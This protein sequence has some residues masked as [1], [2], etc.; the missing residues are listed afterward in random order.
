[1]PEVPQEVVVQI[2][3]AERVS[4][5]RLQEHPR[6]YRSHP[7]EQLAEI[8]A[9][10][11]QHGQY[12]NVVCAEDYTVLAGHGVKQA[13]E[14]LGWTELSVVRLGIAADSAAALK[15]LVA[16]N[17]IAKGA[18]DADT[19]MMAIL[20]V[21]EEEGDLTGSGFNQQQKRALQIVIAPPDNLHKEDAA[22]E[23][24]ATFGEDLQYEEGARAIRLVVQFDSE[25]ARDQFIEQ[26]EFIITSKAKQTWSTWWPPRQKKDIG[27]VQWED[28]DA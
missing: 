3:P 1:M 13:A 22:A 5:E 2:H 7:P 15:V 17:Y 6:N 16:D 12:R 26:Q 25:E 10:L 8:Q 24:A 4:I 18:L 14:E 11:T 21:L 19:E 20:N 23:W 9:S 28:S 27:S